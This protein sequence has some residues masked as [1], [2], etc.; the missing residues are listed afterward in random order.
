[1]RDGAWRSPSGAGRA[2]RGGLRK[3]RTKPWGCRVG[4]RAARLVVRAARLEP[5]GGLSR[6]RGRV[7]WQLT[8]ALCRSPRSAGTAAPPPCPTA[9][10]SS[11]A[12]RGSPHAAVRKPGPAAPSLCLQEG[13]NGQAIQG[14][15]T[16]PKACTQDTPTYIRRPKM[17]RR[18]P[19]QIGLSHYVI[20]R[21]RLLKIPHETGALLVPKNDCRDNVDAF[22]PTNSL[23]CPCPHLEAGPR[24]A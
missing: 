24:K 12:S 10:G 21:K 14:P 19:V 15:S 17:G 6:R 3:P 22:Y 2:Q 18:E 1:M 13:S 5:R 20:T 11:T 4:L 8:S 9:P 7:C 23:G 16:E